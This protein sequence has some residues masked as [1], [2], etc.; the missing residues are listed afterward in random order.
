MCRLPAHTHTHTL[1]RSRM[2]DAVQ[3]AR[4][5][6]AGDLTDIMMTTREE[7]RVLA[8]IARLDAQLHSTAANRY[9]KG[10]TACP[11][12]LKHSFTAGSAA[13]SAIPVKPAS[14]RAAL[15]NFPLSVASER[16]PRWEELSSAASALHASD[17]RSQMSLM[18]APATAM[19]GLQQ[20]TPVPSRLVRDTCF[21][22]S[23]SANYRLF[24]T[25]SLLFPHV[26]RHSPSAAIVEKPGAKAEMIV[27]ISTGAAQLSSHSNSNYGKSERC[28]L[29]RALRSVS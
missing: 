5:A 15:R 29:C 27:D 10:S 17:A 20:Q 18:S 21:C 19:H 24:F 14:A 4:G 2:R 25:R 1:A 7:E 23:A 9:S 8:S 13:D 22:S 6:L 11:L 26:W 28:R 16:P 3:T 12:L